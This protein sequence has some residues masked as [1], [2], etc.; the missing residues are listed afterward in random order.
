MPVMSNGRTE[1]MQRKS[2]LNIHFFVVF[3]CATDFD[4]FELRFPSLQIFFGGMK[5]DFSFSSAGF[6]VPVELLFDFLEYFFFVRRISMCMCVFLN[7]GCRCYIPPLPISGVISF[8]R[9]IR[10]RFSSFFFYFSF[11][12]P[13]FEMFDANTQK[14][15]K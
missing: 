2:F 5:S 15:K 1:R 11:A 13:F 14:Q 10:D 6:F 8:L 4:R 9:F 7:F 3:S 12:L